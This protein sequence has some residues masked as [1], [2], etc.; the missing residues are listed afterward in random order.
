MLVNSSVDETNNT[1]QS[2]SPSI[3][4]TKDR[5]SGAVIQNDEIISPKKKTVTWAHKNNIPD[6]PDKTIVL[7]GLELG[8]EKWQDVDDIEFVYDEGN[9]DFEITW[10]IFEDGD[11]KGW[12]DCKSYL[13][14]PPHYCNLEI[15]LGGTDCN[16]NYV[17]HNKFMVA[18]TVMHEIGHYLGIEH[19]LNE[20]HLMHG[21]DGTSHQYFD[22]MGYEIPKRFPEEYVGR[23]IL[24]RQYEKMDDT[25]T[26]EKQRIQDLQDRIKREKTQFDQKYSRHLSS[27][28]FDGSD[29][30][31]RN[32]L[33]DLNENNRLINRYNSE[34]SEQD[35][36]IDRAND[37][38]KKLN[39]FPSV[40]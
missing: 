27:G 39:C 4:E 36:R 19:T 21:I 28:F 1:S 20:S 10:K 40:E 25:I 3:I 34:I 15:T 22:D 14:A 23:D 38:V 13:N 2:K 6:I 12:A 11:H 35:A 26:K 18:N 8:L 32:Y 9:P 16:R 31:Y 5:E 29:A 7:E 33:D 37:L 17:Q 24:L 30:E